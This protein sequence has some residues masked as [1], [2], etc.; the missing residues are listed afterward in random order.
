KKA[1]EQAQRS[2]AKAKRELREQFE[3][4]V[5]AT[6]DDARQG[7]LGRRPKIEEGA[8]VRLKGIREPARVRRV[9]GEDRIEVEAGFMKM[10]VP[11]EDVL[12]VLPA[13]DAGARLPKNVSFRPAPQLTPSVQEI[14]LIGEH[15]EEAC[16]RVERFLD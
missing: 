12:E 11:I 14:N 3:T 9:M 8:R 4:T 2:V 10:Q 13:A 16:E 1:G 6:K 7:E 15:A 5:L